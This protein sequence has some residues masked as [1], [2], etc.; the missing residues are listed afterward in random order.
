VL[1]LA[2]KR[3]HERGINRPVRIIWTREESIFGH[4]KRHQATVYTK[5]GATKEG[6]IT[7]VSAT[8]H[9]DSGAYA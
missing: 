7:A 2:A 8:V 6:K 3:L 4:H 5:W 9:M 1:G